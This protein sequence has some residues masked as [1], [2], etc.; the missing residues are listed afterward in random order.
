[1]STQDSPEILSNFNPT[2]VILP[3]LIGIGVVLYLVARDFDMEAFQ[4]INWTG[5]TAVLL[6]VAAVFMAIRHYALM[7][8]IRTLTGNKLTWWQTFEVVSLWEFG[9]AATPS[10]V[11]GTA[12]A[13][14]LLTRENLTAGET[15]TV[16]L[17]TIFLDAIFFIFGIPFLALVLGKSLFIPGF[18]MNVDQALSLWLVPCV[19]G[20]IFMVFYTFMI[21]YGLFVKPH[22]VK[23]LLVNVTKISFLKR[24][25]EKAIQTGDDLIVASKGL[26]DKG[27]KFWFAGIWSTLAIWG[28]RFLVLNLVIMALVPVDNQVLLFGRQLILYILMVLAPTP[29]GS[30]IAEI[31]FQALFSDFFLTG[32][33]LANGIPA[34][35]NLLMSIVSLLWR[36]ISY[37]PYLFLGA[38]ILP[39]WLRRVFKKGD[40]ENVK[41]EKPVNW[42]EPVKTSH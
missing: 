14:F 8:R 24:W 6:I 20:Y 40:K 34:V 3:V 13:L 38:I 1:M 15:I 5:G 28:F 32:K 25:Q 2:K 4:A 10:T 42:K 35:N 22:S 31:S 11:G 26:K 16:V 39:A 21:G 33:I 9:S 29:G 12:V 37:Y 27:T 7:Y 30:G 17:F 23:K 18:D 41:Q 36:L 19:I